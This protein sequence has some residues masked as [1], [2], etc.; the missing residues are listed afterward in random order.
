VALS[1]SENELDGLNLGLSSS[2]ESILSRGDLLSLCVCDCCNDASSDSTTEE[3]FLMTD[4][5]LGGGGGGDGGGDCCK[6]RG[7]SGAG[8]KDCCPSSEFELYI[9]C[10][11]LYDGCPGKKSFGD[12]EFLGDD[13]RDCNCRKLRGLSNGGCCD[14]ASSSGSNVGFLGGSDCCELRGLSASDLKKMVCFSSSEFELYI[15]CLGLFDG[16]LL[17]TLPES[18]L[19]GDCTS[20]RGL[21]G[22]CDDVPFTTFC[23][24]GGDCC[25]ATFTRG[26]GGTGF[27]IVGG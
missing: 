7:L 15:L 26:F 11:G 18:L 6:L 5:F 2:C 12:V 1:D 20:T 14:D 3:A 16:L 9:L 19:D 13:D 21:G 4:G 10:L 24:G 23:L 25:D 8:L 22:C 17:S 27:V